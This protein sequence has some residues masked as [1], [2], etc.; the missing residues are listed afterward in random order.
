VEV[1]EDL[2]SKDPQGGGVPQPAKRKQERPKLAVRYKK[3]TSRKKAGEQAHTIIVSVPTGEEEIADVG[4]KQRKRGRPRKTP[5]TDP[6][7]PRKGSVPDPGKGVC[8]D[9]VKGRH[10][11]EEGARSPRREQRAS[12]EFR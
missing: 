8:A 6:V 2:P 3:V 7:D 5:E 9:P 11:G 4:V 10:F 1:K 12:V